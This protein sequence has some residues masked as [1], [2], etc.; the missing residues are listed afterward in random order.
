[1]RKI[2][3]TLIVV[4]ATTMLLASCSTTDSYSYTPTA[5]LELESREVPD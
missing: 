4:A 3:Y 5:D 2:I 1:M